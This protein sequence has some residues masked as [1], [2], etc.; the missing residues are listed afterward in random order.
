MRLF[1]KWCMKPRPGMKQTNRIM[2]TMTASSR[3]VSGAFCPKSRSSGLP[4]STKRMTV[5]KILMGRKLPT[6]NVPRMTMS[7]KNVNP[8]RTMTPRKPM[9]TERMDMKKDPLSNCILIRGNIM[10]AFY[11]SCHRWF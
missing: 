1:V 11:F 2:P 8:Q 4:M 10:V 6:R 9:M 7:L 5:P 3:P